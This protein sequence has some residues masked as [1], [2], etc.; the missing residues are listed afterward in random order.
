MEDAYGVISTTNSPISVGHTNC[1]VRWKLWAEDPDLPQS[2]P[3]DFH[4]TPLSIS[5]RTKVA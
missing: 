5:S 1:L 3:G 2:L 4:P